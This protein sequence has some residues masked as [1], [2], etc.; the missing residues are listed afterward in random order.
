MR[1]ATLKIIHETLAAEL[2]RANESKD[3]AWQE[4]ENFAESCGVSIDDAI[5]RTEGAR[6]YDKYDRA[7][8]AANRI[9]DAMEDLSDHDWS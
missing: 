3:S 2:E 4:L 7:R 1:Y 6:L 5:M 8:N 9:A